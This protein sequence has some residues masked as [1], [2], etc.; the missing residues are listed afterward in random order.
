M[1]I[2]AKNE[3][4]VLPGPFN[5]VAEVKAKNKASGFYFFAPDTIRFFRSK[6]GSTI[7]AGRFFITSEQGPTESDQR[8]WTVR[9]ACDDGR[10]KDLGEFQGYD[11]HSAA[12]RA[13]ARFVAEY[14]KPG[15]R[16]ARWTGSL[17]GEGPTS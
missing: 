11:S 12:A 7:Y 14:R 1:T 10:I 9:I 2:P 8:R 4:I 13:I 15:Q 16:T 6:V 17:R 3:D 5:S